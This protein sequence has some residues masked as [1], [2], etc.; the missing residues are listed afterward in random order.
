[1]YVIDLVVAIFIVAT[2]PKN[3]EDISQ[4]TETDPKFSP[5][6]VIELSID[7]VDHFYNAGMWL[8]KTVHN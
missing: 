6:H 2:F 3:R 8:K 4:V 1:M 5:D 7:G